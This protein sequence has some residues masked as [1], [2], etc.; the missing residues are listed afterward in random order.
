MVK[1][2]KRESIAHFG[3]ALL[4]LA[5]SLILFTIFIFFPLIKSF[6]LSLYTIDL[7]GNEKLFIGFQRYIDL[8]LSAQ[9]AHSLWV[10]LLFTV[11]TVVPGILIALFLAYIANWQLRGIGIFR[12]LFAFPLS[13]AVA[14]TSMIA[15]MMFNPS[16]GVITYFL[17]LFHLPAISWLSDPKWALL[18]I[19]IVAIWRS[20]GFNT[21]VILSGLQSIPQQL[22]ESGRIDG[23]GPWRLFINITLPLL[24][25]VLFFVFI[26]SVVNSLQAFGEVNI[27]TQGGPADS[28]NLIVYS[29]YREGF[30][31]VNY[32]YASAES[33]VLFGIILLLTAFEFW[34]LERKVFY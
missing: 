28:T 7:M 25:P 10:T 29:I 3:E 27:L 21:I 13:I 17:Q 15:M 22:Y 34:V 8:F 30:F 26:V 18:S 24:S 6:R 20:I 5:P 32:G 19:S 4:Y 11:Y 16:S 1:K 31:N 2:H 23:A 9:F 14:S 33:I 12:T